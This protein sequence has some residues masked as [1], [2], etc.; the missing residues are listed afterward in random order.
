MY[1]KIGIHHRVGSF[2]DRWIEYCKKENFQ[3]IIVDCY[4]NDILEVLE[5]E[6][7]TH[8]M[9]HMNHESSIEL[10]V[11]PYVMNAADIMGIKTFPD[12]NTRWHFDDK[13]AQKYLFES[14]QVDAVKSYVFYDRQ[15][16][17]SFIRKAKFPIVAKLKRG[18]GSTNVRLLKTEKEGVKYIEKLFGSGIMSTAKPLENFSQKSKL[19]KKIKNPLE[20]LYKVYSFYKRNQKE[21][22][23]S[24]PE[25]GYVYF[26]EFLPNN[27]YDTRI[28]VIRDI[29]FGIRRFNNDNDFRASGSGKIDYNVKNIDINIVKKA[30][31]ISE[32]LKLQCAAYDFVYDGERNIKVIEVCFGFSMLAYDKCEGYW[33]KDMS[34]TEGQFNPQYFMARYFLSV[35]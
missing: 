22:R 30:F 19:A 32:K 9:W 3:Y 4:S 29:A 33:M 12:F 8:L 21:R 26:Q 27:D 31:E 18:A 14:Q 7:V 2:S 6:K 15:E 23:L 10:M 16:S 35:L 20:L 5:K 11:F 34:F 28:I 13:V 17:I 24:L 25:R 1:I